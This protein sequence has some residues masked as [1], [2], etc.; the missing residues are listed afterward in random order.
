MNFN[1]CLITLIALPLAF[2]CLAMEKENDAKNKELTTLI[3][4]QPA[5]QLNDLP[6]EL[7]AY[8][9]QFLII[10]D[11]PLLSMHYLSRFALTCKRNFTIIMHPQFPFLPIKQLTNDAKRHKSNDISPW[12]GEWKNWN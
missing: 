4:S 11:R 2:S 12:E 5:K 1:Y 8:I 3:K 6:A 9:A 10:Q 7:I